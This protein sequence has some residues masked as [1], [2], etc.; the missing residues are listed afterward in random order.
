MLYREIMAVCS[1]IH[2]K[3]I[4]TVCGQNVDL[5]NVKLLLLVNSSGV[6]GGWTQRPVILNT[7]TDCICNSHVTYQ[8]HSLSPFHPVSSSW[9]STVFNN[10]VR[11]WCTVCCFI[12]C[13]VHWLRTAHTHTHTH[14][15]LRSV[16]GTDSKNTARL[17]GSWWTSQATLPWNV[18]RL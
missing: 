4:N 12:D 18:A 3:H 1:E 9:Y 6:T 5:L 11:C 2:T 7:L 8:Q 15:V 17:Y 16:R 10:I 14:A 13:A